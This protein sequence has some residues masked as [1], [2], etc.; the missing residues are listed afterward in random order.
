MPD[1]GICASDWPWN[2]A[3]QPAAENVS[4]C[5]GCS[6]GPLY[7]RQAPARPS[8]PGPLFSSFDALNQQLEDAAST[9]ARIWRSGAAATR[10]KLAAV[11][12]GWQWRRSPVAH[13]RAIRYCCVS[14]ARRPG[15]STAQIKLPTTLGSSS[16]PELTDH[17]RTSSNLQSPTP[18]GTG[19]CACALDPWTA[20]GPCP[21][22]SH[23]LRQGEGSCPNLLG[24]LQSLCS[25]PRPR[26]GTSTLGDR[27]YGQLQP[28]AEHAVCCPPG[29][30]CSGTC[31]GTCTL[32][33]PTRPIAQGPS[34]S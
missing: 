33:R 31:A 9:G 19:T 27:R 4:Y 29:A 6:R 10:E 14:W 26:A 8:P 21:A 25:S 7:L 28:S 15:A 1:A 11:A 5:E 13:R 18:L 17:S 23:S 12:R 24:S 32:R 22:L 3:S 30:A 34:P 16:A 2:S 20:A